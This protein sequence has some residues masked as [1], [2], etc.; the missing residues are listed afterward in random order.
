[1]PPWMKK[2]IMGAGVIGALGGG[3]PEAEARQPTHET[4]NTSED[5]FAELDGLDD[6]GGAYKVTLDTREEVK[7][8]KKE[9]FERKYNSLLGKM[10]MILSLLER[11][12]KIT[13]KKSDSVYNRFQQ[14]FDKTLNDPNIQ[15]NSAAETEVFRVFADHADVFLAKI[16]VEVAA[17][18]SGTLESAKVEKVLDAFEDLDKTS[19]GIKDFLDPSVDFGTAISK[20]STAFDGKNGVIGYNGIQF[21]KKGNVFSWRVDGASRE[22][23]LT[24]ES[25]GELIQLLQSINERMKADFG[26]D[27][28]AG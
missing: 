9:I 26:V 18:K 27:Y 1:M 13:D 10:K 4:D 15:G 12:G 8:A 25:R 21:V 5:A 3:A 24:N 28:S 2:I 14:V 7:E 11:S 19:A 17:E 23:T 6:E 20:L 22:V 16:Q